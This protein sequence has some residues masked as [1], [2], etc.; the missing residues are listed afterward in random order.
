MVA[1]CLLTV[2]AVAQT[3]NGGLF[4]ANELSVGLGTS[5]VADYH[6]TSVKNAFSTPYNFN[7][8]AGASYFVTRNLGLE[9]WVPFYATKGASVSEV[10]AGAVLRLPL[11]R[12]VPLFKNV[13]PYVGLG[14]AY[15]WNADAKWAYIAKA[16]VEFR[17]NKKW[18]VFAEGQY[19]NAD[20]RL[21]NGA[22]TA[23][24]GIRLV[25]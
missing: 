9:A 25:F 2:S 23:A 21:N 17:L 5:Y 10:Q 3:T 16:G 20:L 6:A 7:L 1:L 11:S 19:R 14:G 18:G 8:E 22:T 15:A 4:N 12:T 24:G 13:A